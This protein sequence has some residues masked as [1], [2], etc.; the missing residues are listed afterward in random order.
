VLCANGLRQWTAPDF[1]FEQLFDD[2]NDEIQLGQ[3]W[4][5]IALPCMAS[6]W[7][8]H[9]ILRYWRIQQRKIA[10]FASGLDERLDEGSPLRVLGDTT[11]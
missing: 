2:E 1:K 5:E 8:N 7:S 11:L 3:V 10:A 6:L 4:E 9:A